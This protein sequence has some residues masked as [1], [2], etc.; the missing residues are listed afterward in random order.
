MAWSHNFINN[1]FIDSFFIGV[2]ANET[3]P[4]LIPAQAGIQLIKICR[5][6]P[7]FVFL[8][9]T[10]LRRYERMMGL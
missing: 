5:A 2:L 6:K 10:D 4:P 8:L 9:D 1:T 3:P 7:V